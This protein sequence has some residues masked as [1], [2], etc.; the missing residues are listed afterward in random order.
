MSEKQPISPE[1]AAEVSAHHVGTE[2]DLAKLEENINSQQ[3]AHGPDARGYTRFAA[4]LGYEHAQD[5]PVRA[6]ED[7]M[8]PLAVGGSALS[9]EV[10]KAR[11]RNVT[12]AML[13]LEA[14]EGSYRTAAAKDALESGV[15][16]STP[17]AREL[18]TQSLGSEFHERWRQDWHEQNEQKEEPED[19]RPKKTTDTAWINKNGTDIVDIANTSFEDLPTDWQA[20]NAAAAEVV[21]GIIDSLDGD[22]DLGNDEV[23]EQVGSMV[24]DAWLERNAWARGGKLDVPFSELPKEEQDKDIAQMETA[25]ELFK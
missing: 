19:G 17:E 3:V 9:E 14:N 25:L 11:E 21:V 24:H 7:Q 13:H 2:K 22:V 4:D 18:A 15:W 10:S 16:V 23:R 5:G 1:L 20:E 12:G 8:N 6:Q